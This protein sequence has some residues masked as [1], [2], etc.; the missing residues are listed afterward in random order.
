[1]PVCF[2]VCANNASCTLYQDDFIFSRPLLHSYKCAEVGDRFATIII[3]FKNNNYHHYNYVVITIFHNYII[4]IIII[5]NY[6]IILIIYSIT[7][8]CM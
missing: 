5:N 6:K 2:I 3:M 7:I 8:L 4:I 1:M